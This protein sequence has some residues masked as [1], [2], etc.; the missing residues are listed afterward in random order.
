MLRYEHT[1]LS[2]LI[3]ALLATYVCLIYTAGRH[4][5]NYCLLQNVIMMITVNY[6]GDIIR[7]VSNY[8]FACV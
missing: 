4:D 7:N 8:I 3:N 1:T 6:H 2:G 5:D